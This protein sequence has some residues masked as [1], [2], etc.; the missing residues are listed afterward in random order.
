VEKIRVG[1]IGAGGIAA[2]WH[3][4]ELSAIDEF[5]ILMLAGRK[6]RRLERLADQYGGRI[7]TNYDE[8]INASDVD[9]VVIATPHPLHVDLAIRAIRAGKHVLV[10]KPLCG[11]LEQ[12]NRF[13]EVA[14]AAKTCVF[15]L[16]HF[17]SDLVAIRRLVGSGRIGEVSGAYA[18]TSHGG[19]E[20]YYASV[21]QIFGE[22]D[23]DL[24]FFDIQRASVGALF[25]MGIYAVA[26]LVAVL[27]SVT[28]VF[29]R[30]LRLNKPTALEDTAL[31]VMEFA[32]GCVGIA[33]TSWCDPAWTWTLSIHGTEAKITAEGRDNPHVAVWT[34]TTKL[35]EDAPVNVERVDLGA[36]P[37]ANA[38]QTWR[39][40][41]RR[42]CQP[43][44]SN[45]QMARHVTEVLLA[46]LESSRQRQPIEVHSRL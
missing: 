46:G 27:G 9:A 7:T 16:P 36:F 24:W 35:R 5:A 11:D 37:A 30:T 13:A 22:T 43:E 20:L 39:Q 12:A 26:R 25:D 15:C 8:V 4:P 31:L 33:E 42:S 17:G 10:Q 29:G 32:C 23:E 19:P 44:L 18:R 40:C 14:A 38:H 28:Q 6:L 3:L 1:V 45:W 34:P 41:I 21:R 2:R